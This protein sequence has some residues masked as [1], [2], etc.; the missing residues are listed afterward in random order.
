M[1]INRQK[2]RVVK[3]EQPGISVS[4]LGFTFRYDR[5]VWQRLPNG[6][7]VLRPARPQE[8]A[9]PYL[10]VFPSDQ[11]LARL[12]ERIRRLTGTSR[13]MV[14]VTELIGDV[15]R[16]L[17]GW[18]N[19]FAHGHPRVAFRKVNWYV[20]RS[21]VRHLRRRSQRPFRPPKGVSYLTQL[22]RLGLQLL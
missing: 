20:T 16:L 1:T 9:R 13:C 6:R 22:R 4:F 12:R 14:P 17:R 7:R 2:T 8:A 5:N 10:N 15:N 21:V 18:K 3:L 11:A 19:Y